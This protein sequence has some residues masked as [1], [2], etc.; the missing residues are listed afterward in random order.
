MG[1]ATTE[2]MRE[3]MA[4]LEEPAFAVARSI[5]EDRMKRDELIRPGS[6]LSDV[7]MEKG[8]VMLKYGPQTVATTI[9]I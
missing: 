4:R 5:V 6:G 2:R 8:T 7:E 3:T 9:V 1:K